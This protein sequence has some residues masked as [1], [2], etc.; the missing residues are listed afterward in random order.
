MKIDLE[1]AQEE[2]IKYTECYDLT[3][4]N[5]DRKQKHS[6]RV[7]QISNK[8]AKELKLSQEEIDIFLAA[9]KQCLPKNNWIELGLRGYEFHPDLLKGMSLKHFSVTCNEFEIN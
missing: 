1:K 3:D 8:I 7:M 4:E 2:F 6:L 5:L 9:I